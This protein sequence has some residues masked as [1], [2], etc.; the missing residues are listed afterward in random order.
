M[1][2]L[3]DEDSY[4]SLEELPAY[5][6]ELTDELT[7]CI[8]CQENGTVLKLTHECGH[9]YIHNKCL[10][11]WFTVNP[12]ECF[13]CRK[14]FTNTDAKLISNIGADLS[15]LLVYDAEAMN[16]IMTRKI[17]R[18]QLLC[19]CIPLLCVII[20]INLICIIISFAFNFF[21]VP[22][23]FNNTYIKFR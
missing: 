5:Q 20:L 18:I 15:Y 11:E 12:N 9:W 23:Q 14:N 6:D 16:H 4:D 3:Q 7:N 19:Y 17:R 8:I 13:I 2:L 22:N 10:T 1:E 21:F